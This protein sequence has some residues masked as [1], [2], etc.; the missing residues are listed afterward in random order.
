RL[1]VH[2]ANLA[3]IQLPN[4]PVWLLT[5]RQHDMRADQTSIRGVQCSHAA[6][7]YQLDVPSINSLM[8]DGIPIQIKEDDA[9]LHA[10]L[11]GGQQMP[12][13]QEEGM[14]PV[15]AAPPRIL[16]PWSRNMS[17]NEQLRDWSL[18]LTHRT[19]GQTIIT[20]KDVSLLSGVIQSDAGI[21]IDLAA[22]GV[23]TLPGQYQIT[24]RSKS[25]RVFMPQL[26]M[27]YVPNL[28]LI[29]QTP[30]ILPEAVTPTHQDRQMAPEI[31]LAAVPDGWAIE[32]ATWD[33]GGQKWRCPV[34][35]DHHRVTLTFVHA[36]DTQQRFAVQLTIPRLEIIYRHQRDQIVAQNTSLS[37]DMSWYEH[38]QPRIELQLAPESLSTIRTFTLSVEVERE[39]TQEPP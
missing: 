6:W 33:A 15:Y 13:V 32:G 28:R 11:V 36:Q 24:V 39:S 22:N 17:K 27:V 1:M 14:V 7:L 9:Q 37:H 5:A 34:G 29:S 19:S 26:S 18:T 8:V 4:Q 10:R 30:V 38:V 23:D 3:Q 2:D 21:E 16:L 25:G 35:T 31:Q 12:F 20:R